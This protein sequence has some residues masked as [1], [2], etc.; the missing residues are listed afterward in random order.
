MKKLMCLILSAVLMLGVFAGCASQK[1]E[2]DATDYSTMTIEELK[3]L[4]KTITS[5]KLTMVTSPDFAPYEFYALGENS[6][7]TLAGFDIA[8]AHYIA[9]FLGL[10]LEIIPMML[11]SE[12]Y[13]AWLQRLVGK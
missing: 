2:A 5:G 7:P 8:L 12:N 13:I 11:N 4:I 10:E 9:D 3:P 1:Q 6:K